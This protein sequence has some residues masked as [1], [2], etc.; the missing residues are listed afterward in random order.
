[1]KFCEIKFS[2]ILHSVEIPGFFYHSDL[3][4]INFGEFRNSKDAVFAILGF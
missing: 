3:R 2:Q 1:M 4:E